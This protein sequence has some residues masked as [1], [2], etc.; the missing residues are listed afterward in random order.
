MSDKSELLFQWNKKG[1]EKPK[2]NIDEWIRIL[3]YKSRPTL[4]DQIDTVEVFSNKL[5]TVREMLDIQKQL[6]TWR[7]VSTGFSAYDQ[8]MY[9][10]INSFNAIT[11]ILNELKSSRAPVSKELI[12]E[13]VWLEKYKNELQVYINKKTVDQM[14]G[15]DK[16]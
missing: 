11:E 15:N 13:F 6:I 4:Q 8:R 16:K 5:K 12:T 9:W 1:L 14:L 3:E 2:Q 7:L 10:W